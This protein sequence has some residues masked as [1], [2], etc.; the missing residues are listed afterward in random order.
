MNLTSKIKD[1]D[2]NLSLEKCNAV[3]GGRSLIEA[4]PE[5][6]SRNY[7]AELGKDRYNIELWLKFL[8]V[9]VGIIMFI[10]FCLN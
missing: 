7:N 1:E 10:F 9:Q 6:K 4:T 5:A 3:Q 8:A 2:G